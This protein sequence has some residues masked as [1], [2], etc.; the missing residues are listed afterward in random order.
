MIGLGSPT[1]ILPR[2]TMHCVRYVTATTVE[3]SE[4]GGLTDKLIGERQIP[5]KKDV[6]VATRRR[7]GQVT[8]MTSDVDDSSPRWLVA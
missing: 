2:L 1:G 4:Q 3:A 5:R 6:V 7:Q 8:L